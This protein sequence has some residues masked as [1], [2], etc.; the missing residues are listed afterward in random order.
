MAR[1]SPTARSTS[2][3]IWAPTASRCKSSSSSRANR[4]VATRTM[5]TY[6]RHARGL[7]TRVRAW[8]RG[9][10]QRLAYTLA[11][12]RAARSRRVA[13]RLSAARRARGARGRG[14]RHDAD[15]VA[16]SGRQPA[17]A[18]ATSAET[19][20]AMQLDPRRRSCLARGLQRMEPI[21]RGVTTA[22][23]ALRWHAANFNVSIVGARGRSRSSLGAPSRLPA[24]D[25]RGHLAGRAAA[26]DHLPLVATIDCP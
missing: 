4:R 1:S 11:D 25:A 13:A 6:P 16:T 8:R 20:R 26:S 12:R 9:V 24:S 19:L 15:H 23:R 17:R 2:S 7:C 21:Q 14:R 18:C 5:G 3:A 10:R 22:A